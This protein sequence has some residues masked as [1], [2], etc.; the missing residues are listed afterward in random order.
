MEWSRYTAS[1][2]ADA[3]RLAE[4][5]DGHMD[6]KVPSCPEWTVTD[7]VHHLGEVYEHKTLCIKLGA[8]PQPWPPERAATAPLTRMR[9]G[10]GHLLAEFTGREAASPAYTWYDPDQ[11]VGFWARRMA[12]ETAVHRADAEL[13]AGVAITPIAEDIA[14][15]GVDE[16]L[17]IFFAWAFARW[18]EECAPV[19]AEGTG[20]AVVI[21][22]GDREFTVR[23]TPE[24]VTV[25]EGDTPADPAVRIS[26]DPTDV[27]LWLWRRVP[28][29]KVTIE[30]DAE[31][32]ERLHRML[33]SFTQ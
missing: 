8:E 12:Q 31:E 11:T 29:D 21:A 7:L 27:L 3:A 26:G 17:T 24:S 30:G 28:D 22:T 9:T 10:L 33:A 20:E 1:L 19:V 6:A 23:V 2:T 32:A 15:D 14:V 5:V 16:L 25:T 13:A 4:V 18:P